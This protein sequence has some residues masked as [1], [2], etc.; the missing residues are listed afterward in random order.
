M[1]VSTAEFCFD[2]LED[3]MDAVNGE[4]SRHAIEVD[5]KS[6]SKS[7]CVRTFSTERGLQTKPPRTQPLE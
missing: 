3:I 7:E 5:R 2:E 6:R 4:N 1:N